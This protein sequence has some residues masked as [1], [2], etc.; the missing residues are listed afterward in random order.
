MEPELGALTAWKW[1]RGEW[2]HRKHRTPAQSPRYTSLSLELSSH[3]CEGVGSSFRGA[4]MDFELVASSDEAAWSFSPD[5]MDD[6]AL[7]PAAWA[8]SDR[9]EWAH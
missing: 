7:D 5:P 6:L 2:Q 1:N 8:D 9:E 3:T 4:G